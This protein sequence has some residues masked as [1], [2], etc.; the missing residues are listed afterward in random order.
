MIIFGGECF[1][2]DVVVLH[3]E[4][5]NEIKM[6]MKQRILHNAKGYVLGGLAIVAAT[7]MSCSNKENRYVFNNAQDAVTT[8][9]Q[10]LAMLR[11]M[12]SANIEE[13]AGLT[14]NWI[15]LQDSTMNV[16]MRDSTLRNDAVLT[17][18]YFATADSIRAEI[19]RL[20]M[21]EKRT[22]AEVVNLKI[23]VSRKQGD[24]MQSGQM[25]EARKFYLDFNKRIIQS[26]VDVRSQMAKRN[27]ELTDQQRSNY[28]WLLIQPFL[29]MDNYGTAALTPQQEK[30]LVELAEQ[31]PELLAAL[32][33]HTDQGD[34]EKLTGVL[35]EYFL[36]SYLKS[37]L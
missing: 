37:V 17:M 12:A 16:M 32:D 23:N 9:H 19:M 24:L 3:P 22:M 26:A 29:V 33:G 28:R 11:P 13:L 31:L 18:D 20:A 30:L 4:I 25:S 5:N 8:C 35:S 10:E 36:K 14:A 6:R 7:L 21:S 2:E 27:G 1:V 34:A 15:E